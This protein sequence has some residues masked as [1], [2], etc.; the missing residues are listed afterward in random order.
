MVKFVSLEDGDFQTICGHLSSMVN[1]APQK[2][3][4]KWKEDS[5]HKG[6]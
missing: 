3:A 2:I 4:E 1:R 5:R 6:M